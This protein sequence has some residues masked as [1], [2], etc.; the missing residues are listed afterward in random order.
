MT[1]PVFCRIN[2]QL[3][4]FEVETSNHAVAITAVKT[5]LMRERALPDGAVLALINTPQ[6]TSEEVAP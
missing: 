5:A 2:G 6:D 4:R 3:A 1:T